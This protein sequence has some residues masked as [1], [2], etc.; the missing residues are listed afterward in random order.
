MEFVEVLGIAQEGSDCLF[1]GS[2]DSG[3][4]EIL[5]HHE[6]GRKLT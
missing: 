5:C 6:A 2:R 3:S 4:S 1:G